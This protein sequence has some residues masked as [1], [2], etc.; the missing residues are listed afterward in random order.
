[1][2][3]SSNPIRILLVEDSG[4]QA[5]ATVK[6]LNEIGYSSVVASPGVDQA[7]ELLRTRSFDVILCDWSMPGRSGLDLLKE[8]REIPELSS[9]PF[10]FL[11]AHAEKEIVMEAV[12]S[13][14]TDYLV[15]PPQAGILKDK[16]RKLS[17]Q[18]ACASS[19]ESV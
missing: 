16:L 8:V 15:K 7:L 13:G 18:I 3:P 17:N 12:K 10:I 5:K 6:L 11:T 9:K 2:E 4:I 19:R 14:A 1:M